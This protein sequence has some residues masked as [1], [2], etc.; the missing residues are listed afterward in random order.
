MK[1]LWSRHAATHLEY[2][3][4]EFTS[5]DPRNETCRLITAMWSNIHYSKVVRNRN[6]AQPLNQDRIR[7]LGISRARSLP[8]PTIWVG[9]GAEG[10]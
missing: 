1:D 9:N 7:Q 10:R 8:P 6:H 2:L 3:R 4:D 5:S